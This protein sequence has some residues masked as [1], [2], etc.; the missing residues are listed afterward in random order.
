VITGIGFLG[1]GSVIRS[2]G[3]V[4]GLTT[5]A[6]V[7]MVAAI[8]VAVGM[9]VYP[10]AVTG[11]N[12]ISTSENSIVLRGS[13]P[14]TGGATMATG[15]YTANGAATQ[16]ITGLGFRPDVVIVK[17]DF[18]DA[19][20]D[21]LSS[22]VIRTSTMAGANSKPMKGL[23]ALLGNLITS[24]DVDGFTVGNDERVNWQAG[25]CGG[26]CTYRWVAFK[27]T[28]NLK[29]GT[30]TGNPPGQSITGVGFSPEYVIG[31]PA[32]A[33]LVFQ[34]TNQDTNTYAF[35]AGAALAGRI[36]TLDPDGFTVNN[37]PGVNGN[38]IVYHYVAFNE[39]A[40]QLKLGTYA[41]AAGT[42]AIAGVGFQPR[43]MIV[44]GLSPATTD[45]IQAS[46]AMPAGS[47]LNFRNASNGN[48]I[49]ALQADGFQVGANTDVNSAGTSYAYVA[50]GDG[51]ES[52]DVALAS[53][54]PGLSIATTINAV[55]VESLAGLSVR[56]GPLFSAVAGRLPDYIAHSLEYLGLTLLVVRALNGGFQ[57]PISR[58]THVSAVAMM[59]ADEASSGSPS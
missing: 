7:W 47:S 32:N 25:N 22:A 34:R 27:A 17:V 29:V 8:G 13:A 15:S 28:G 52:V 18:S 53:I 37:S 49:T 26:T 2:G 44:K 14:F 51:S 20:N 54:R 41:G 39:V 42:Q 59:S 3:Y 19:V 9:H 23:Q 35:Q 55:P 50:F 45:P 24:L 36:T 38:G 1:A 5:A 33:R 46:D 21:D 40:G 58:L 57:S 12:F 6:S 10:L 30:Y 16:A 4:H 56:G 48:S 11:T 31:I 43:Y